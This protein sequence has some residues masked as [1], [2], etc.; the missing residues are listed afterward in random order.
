MTSKEQPVEI[1]F[2]L[3]SL[4]DLVARLTRASN[5]IEAELDE[6]DREVAALESTWT[7]EAGAAYQVAHREWNEALRTINTTLKN[8]G[9]L[10]RAHSTTYAEAE[11]KIASLFD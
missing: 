2:D 8:S 7:G 5:R 4:D 11:A 9:R 10:A 3:P 1:V 6:L